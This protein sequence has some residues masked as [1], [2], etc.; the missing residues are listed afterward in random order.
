LKEA[1]GAVLAGATW[2]R[3]RTHFVRNLQS[4]VPRHAQDGG[5]EVDV[6]PLEAGCF[7]A[8]QPDGDRDGED[9][10]AK[11]SPLAASSSKWTSSGLSARTSGRT[12]L[13]GSTSLAG[14]RDARVG[15]R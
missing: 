3:C 14:G 6:R 5:V 4:K 11:R 9:G 7:A 10:F 1:I 13:G 15:S 8:A 2:Q 12:A